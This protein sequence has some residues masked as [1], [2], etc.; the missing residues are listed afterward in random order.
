[1][2][3]RSGNVEALEAEQTAEAQ[4]RLENLRELVTAASE[5]DRHGEVEGLQDFLIQTAL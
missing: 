4:A 3:I 2:L 5:F 1:V